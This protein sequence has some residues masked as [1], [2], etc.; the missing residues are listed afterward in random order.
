VVV[1]V[2]PMDLAAA[3]DT[4]AVVMVVVHMVVG[5]EA[6]RIDS[7]VVLDKETEDTGKPSVLVVVGLVCCTLVLP[8]DMA[9]MF[10]TDLGSVVVLGIQD[11][12]EA[13]HAVLGDLEDKGSQAGQ[14][15]RCSRR[16]TSCSR[17]A[18]VAVEEVWLHAQAR[19]SPVYYPGSGV[20]WRRKSRWIQENACQSLAVGGAG[21]C[22]R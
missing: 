21:I 17:E 18:C 14:D 22:R 9:M 13:V 5:S 6:A 16:L 19:L 12:E 7:V 3:V 10:R 15:R 8:A 1:V 11:V 20:Y 2:G 4:V